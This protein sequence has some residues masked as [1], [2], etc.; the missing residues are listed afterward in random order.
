MLRVVPV[1]KAGLRELLVEAGDGVWAGHDGGAAGQSDGLDV[2][3]VAAEQ[4]GCL[5]SQGDRNEAQ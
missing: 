5:V 3:G 4:R 2:D 1:G